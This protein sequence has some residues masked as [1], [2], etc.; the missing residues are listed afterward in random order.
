[1]VAYAADPILPKS[2]PNNSDGY[3]TELQTQAKNKIG[4]DLESRLAANPIIPH[5]H[6]IY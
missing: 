5:I 3:A 4:G 2:Q 1:M 6:V